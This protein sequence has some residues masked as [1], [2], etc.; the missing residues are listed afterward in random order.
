MTDSEVIV[1]KGSTTF[2]GPDGVALYRAIALR[3]G[4]AMYAKCGLKPNRAWT[5]TAMLQAAGGITGKIYK[6]GQY[7]I[8]ADD[9]TVWIEAMKAAIPITREGE[10]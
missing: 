6:R 2:A 8:A 1:Q 5:P 10:S 4:L 9:L 7:Q 3:S